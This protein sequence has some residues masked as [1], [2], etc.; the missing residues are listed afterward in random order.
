[1]KIVRNVGSVGNTDHQADIPAP[2]RT[3][4]FAFP[5]VVTIDWAMMLQS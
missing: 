3:A 4:Y 2:P 1:M 5:L